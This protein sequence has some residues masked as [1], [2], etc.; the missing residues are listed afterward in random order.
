MVFLIL[1]SLPTPYPVHNSGV[2]QGE[3]GQRYPVDMQLRR[4]QEGYQV[5]FQLKEVTA[6]AVITPDMMKLIMP[7][8]VTT[9]DLDHSA[10][11][12]Q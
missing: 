3:D 4:P 8:D 10:G 7:N 12:Q 6:G 9:V 1:F 2:W 11:S 5:R